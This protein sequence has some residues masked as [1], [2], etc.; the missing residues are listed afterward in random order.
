MCV[1]G[2]V[3]SLCLDGSV[4]DEE[5]R[6]IAVTLQAFLEMTEPVQQI[7]LVKKVSSSSLS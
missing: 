4:S 1:L 2:R 3:A 6:Q 7:Q 5:V